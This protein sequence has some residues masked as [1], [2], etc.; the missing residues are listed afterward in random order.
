MPTM[1]T[2]QPDADAEDLD[3]LDDAADSDSDDDEDLL[4]QQGVYNTITDRIKALASI[5]EVTAKLMPCDACGGNRGW[6]HNGR[7]VVQVQ[8]LALDSLAALIAD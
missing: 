2:E 4:E 1:R 7:R 5:V 3:D 8:R 6:S